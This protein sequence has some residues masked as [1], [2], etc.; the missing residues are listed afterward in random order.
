MSEHVPLELQ[1]KCVRRELALRR[2][3]YPVRVRARKM[4]GAEA[5][6]EIERMEAVLATLEW[7]LDNRQALHELQLRATLST[8]RQ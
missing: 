4:N 2:N 7:C 8:K 3:V 6:E 1:I 5:A